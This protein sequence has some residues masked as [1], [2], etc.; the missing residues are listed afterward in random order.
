MT[1]LRTS[2]SSTPVTR[3]SI[4]CSILRRAHSAAMPGSS[5]ATPP[6]VWRHGAPSAR[7]KA[8]V[9]SGRSGVPGK[10]TVRTSGS[11][12]YTSGIACGYNSTASGQSTSTSLKAT[13]SSFAN[14][15][16]IL[17]LTSAVSPMC[18]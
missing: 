8:V 3:L 17:S 1:S 6:T 7:P 16:V 4:R 15:A 13:R 18:V 12:A 9:K 5:L 11:P 2:A 14:K 10:L